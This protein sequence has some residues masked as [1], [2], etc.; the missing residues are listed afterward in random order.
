MRYSSS[1]FN[2]RSREGSDC[3]LV[4]SLP[5]LG[6]FNSRSREGSD[7]IAV[8]E[9]PLLGVSIHAPA[10]GATKTLTSGGMTYKF[11]FTLPRG[12]RHP[13]VME[14]QRRF[15]V[16]IHAPARGATEPRIYT[17]RSCN[18]SIHAPARGATSYTLATEQSGVFQFT[19]PR[20]E[21][22]RRLLRDPLCKSFNSRSR[23]GSDAR[24]SSTLARS[25]VSIHAPA[26]GAT[27]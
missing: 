8:V 11:Q 25:K 12:E 20:G 27:M 24:R 7:H 17:N 18:V 2:S 23:E 1:S 21:R 5:L 22:L 9:Y 4:S 19:L 15:F 6:C 10:R 26:R 13:Q 16:S 14:I 3:C